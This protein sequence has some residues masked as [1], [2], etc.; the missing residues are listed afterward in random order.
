MKPEFRV[1]QE[2]SNKMWYWQELQDNF[3]PGKI[4]DMLNGVYME[5]V[6]QYTGLKDKNGKEIWE[7]DIVKWET[8]KGIGEVFWDSDNAWWGLRDH[9]GEGSWL[10]GSN[11]VC[12]VIG[13]IYENPDLLEKG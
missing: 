3:T 2:S 10:S 4:L 12:E 9:D 6:M 5:A 8:F 11:S 1:Y 7:G 13:N